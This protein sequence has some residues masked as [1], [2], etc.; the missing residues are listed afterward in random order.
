MFVEF[1]RWLPTL[2]PGFPSHK[3]YQ[4]KEIREDKDLGPMLVVHV[5]GNRVVSRGTDTVT[6][7]ELFANRRNVAHGV[8]VGSP[9]RHVVF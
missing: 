7:L 3:V 1:L 4:D 5:T 2:I 8:V 9:T 6:Q